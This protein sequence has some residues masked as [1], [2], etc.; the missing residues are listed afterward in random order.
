M[1]YRAKIN[2]DK[3]DKPSVYVDNQ[4]CNLKFKDDTQYEELIK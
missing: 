2:K 1:D 3:D 4:L